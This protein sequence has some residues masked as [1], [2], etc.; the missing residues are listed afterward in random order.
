MNKKIKFLSCTMCGL[1]IGS[2]LAL[3]NV[4]A[5]SITN[6]DTSSITSNT[7]FEHKFYMVRDNKVVELSDQDL[8]NMNLKIDRNTLEVRRII[9]KRDLEPGSQ[10]EYYT[11]LTHSQVQELLPVIS[12]ASVDL[13]RVASICGV[14][15]ASLLV[16]FIAGLTKTALRSADN[17]NGVNVYRLN[18]N[19]GIFTLTPR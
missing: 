16:K 19:Y 15:Q 14:P 12:L 5:K 2:N 7:S 10:F 1:L 8:A 13:S 6:V 17:G 11:S 4:H 9:E 18:T 3:T